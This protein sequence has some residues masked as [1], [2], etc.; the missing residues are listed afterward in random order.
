MAGQPLYLS[1]VVE[2]LSDLLIPLGQFN[3]FRRPPQPLLQAGTPAVQAG[4]H[5]VI[6][7][8]QNVSKGPS[9]DQDTTNWRNQYHL[10]TGNFTVCTDP[11]GELFGGTGMPYNLLVDPRTMKI[12]EA[13]YYGGGQ[14]GQATQAAN[15]F[16][17]R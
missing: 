6:L 11:K 10:N 4:V 5:W 17:T 16:K 9:T 8:V 15:V 3:K 13:V 12:E 2:D 14:V 7:M 1:R